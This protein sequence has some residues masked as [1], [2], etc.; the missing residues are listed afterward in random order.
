[1]AKTKQ[2]EQLSGGV[3]G[4]G[5]GRHMPTTLGILLYPSL[6]KVARG[7][8]LKPEGPKLYPF[9]NRPMP[10]NLLFRDEEDWW[11]KRYRLV[12]AR[13]AAW[14]SLAHITITGR[15]LLLQAILY[16]SLRYWLFSASSYQR[17]SLTHSKKTR[18][19]SSGLNHPK[20]SQTIKTAR[21][22]PN[23]EHT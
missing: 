13:I 4:G 14:K 1:M 2:L 18:T 8:P 16:G 3:D 22:G 6:I 15:N 19:T 7:E 9:G 21:P 10:R 11:H 12:K 17:A 23:Q 5:G 20:Y